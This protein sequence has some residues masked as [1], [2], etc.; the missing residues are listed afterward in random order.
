MN[1]LIFLKY[2]TSICLSRPKEST[3]WLVKKSGTVVFKS[4]LWT[5]E[6]PYAIFSYI[7]IVTPEFLQHI[8]F[9]VLVKQTPVAQL[10]SATDF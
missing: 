5:R 7:I 9:V 4:L 3:E 8:D 6:L 2:Q 10:D 1:F